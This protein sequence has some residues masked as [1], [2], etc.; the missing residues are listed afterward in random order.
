M[1]DTGLD[2]VNNIHV[3]EHIL[4]I[5]KLL[6]NVT[7]NIGEYVYAV[8]GRKVFHDASKCYREGKRGAAGTYYLFI[9]GVVRIKLCTNTLVWADSKQYVTQHQAC[10]VSSH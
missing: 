10:H 5:S 9:C 7:T 4:L 1:L 2:V 8:V 3:Q 6:N